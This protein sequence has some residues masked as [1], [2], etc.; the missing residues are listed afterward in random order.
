MVGASALME[1]DLADR[2]ERL[3]QTVEMVLA[4]VMAQEGEGEVAERSGEPVQAVPSESSGAKAGAIP[5]T[6]SDARRTFGKSAS[7]PPPCP[8]MASFPLA[9]A[10]P[11]TDHR[12]TKT[13]PARPGA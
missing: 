1:L 5:R 6:R 8:P 9:H 11:E 7:R 13:Y 12:A 4:A 2:T 10:P 3:A